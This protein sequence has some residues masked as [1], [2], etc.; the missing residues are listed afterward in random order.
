MFDEMKKRGWKYIYG[1][2]VFRRRGNHDL[3]FELVNSGWS[4]KTMKW[5]NELDSSRHRSGRN[6]VPQ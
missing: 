2:N 1:K 4:R 3:H 5:L 6:N